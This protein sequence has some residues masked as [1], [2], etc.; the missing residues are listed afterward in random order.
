MNKKV[1]IATVALATCMASSVALVAAGCSNGEPA[2]GYSYRSAVSALATT[3][4]PH[5]WE[6]NADSEIA[7]YVTSPLVDITA[8]ANEGDVANKIFQWKYEM[9]TKV[10]DVTNKA[11][12]EDVLSKYSKNIV[13]P[14]NET[15]ATVTDGYVF[16]IKLK[17]DAK[18]ENGE[19]ITAD[20]Y[21]YSMQQLL[22]P[23]MKNYRANLYISNETELAGAYN[24]YYSTDRQIFVGVGTQ[25]ATIQAA[26]DANQTVYLDMWSFWGLQGAKDAQGNE[27]PQYVSI[28]DTTEYR[29]LAVAEGEDGDWI[30]ANAIYN[31]YKAQL[32][33]GAA[34]SSY[35]GLLV[36]NDNYGALWEDVGF[37]KV[38][39]YTV[40]YVT[41]VHC[42]YYT[43]MTSLTSNWL[44]YKDLYEE[45]KTTTGSL[46]TTNYG[47]SKETTMS[48]GVYKFDSIDAGSQMRLSQN[49][50]W[51][52]WAKDEN[53]DPVTD[54]YGNLVS[55]ITIDG[56][57]VRQ[58]QT[59]NIRIDVMTA[60]TQESAFMNGELTTWTPAAD[61]LS[62][63]AQSDYLF[64]TP[65][66]YTMSFFFNTD[67]AAL[68]KMETAGTVT[69]GL[70]LTNTDFRH[71]MSLAINRAEFVTATPGYEAAYS[72]MNELYYYNI[73]EDPTSSY[74]GSKEAMMAICDL[75]GA[76]YDAD[77][78]ASIQSAYSKI[79]GYDLAQAQALM[80]KACDQLADVD[81]IYTRGEPI[82]F[83]IAWTVG[84]IDSSDRSQIDLLQRYLNEA[85]EGSGFGTITLTPIG[86]MQDV[87][88]YDAVPN[89]TYA[90][91]Y[92]AW[93][94]AYL[95]PFRNF[96]VYMDPDQYAVNELGC[97]DPTIYEF[98]LNVPG[99]G[100]RTMTAKDWSNSMSGSGM[101]ATASAE[102]KLS[103]TAQLEKEYLSLYYRI[104]ICNTVDSYLLSQ[105]VSWYL[106][107]DEW[108]VLY[109]F[110]GLRLM[111]YNYT[112]GEWAGIAKDAAA[113]Y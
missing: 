54:E 39:D 101:Y 90:I 24:Y 71:A 15:A 23:Q 63:Y 57:Q 48:C 36:D 7:M 88:P 31:A 41:A 103:I 105:Q 97:W 58:Y 80:K 47:T 67:R 17:P 61:D 16:E 93:G 20:D 99:E 64:S 98:T 2:N 12:Y 84:E 59:T 82:E 40:V 100:K 104:P 76:T 65:V 79:T 32:E 85:A 68:E 83:E 5:T 107:R 26:L 62:S 56:K 28:S 92:G 1:K 10:T 4:N 96:Q 3:W 46:V 18:W 69:N 21:V 33:V 112:N 60:S 53:G 110:G 73:Y 51:Y 42:D 75:Y 78:L 22:N 29:D 86:N 111:Q 8:G 109:E 81:K 87:T 43:F 74:R 38:D 11:G 94:G 70:V 95:Y 113:D 102:V 37:Y 91:G 50:Y 45:G 13:F 9:A 55:Y 30:S 44:V 34:A 14:E 106:D 6:T 89:G 77:D 66:T 49:P 72:L 52:G 27:C 108:Y 25:Y 19:A 35:V